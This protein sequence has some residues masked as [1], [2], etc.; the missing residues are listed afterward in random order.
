MPLDLDVVL[1]VKAIGKV[2][3]RDLVVLRND[4]A[5]AGDEVLFL[6]TGNSGHGM[7]GR[8]SITVQ[9]LH[10]CA[11]LTS[12]Y[13][14]PLTPRMKPDAAFGVIH[15]AGQPTV[16]VEDPFATS[17]QERTRMPVPGILEIIGEDPSTGWLSIPKFL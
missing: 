9:N 2:V 1:A 10:N 16:A 17:I 6:L 5:D 14:P 13:H 8:V 3:E 12:S 11:R 15:P 4:R 7:I